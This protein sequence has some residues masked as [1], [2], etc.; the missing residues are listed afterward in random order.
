MKKNLLSVGYVVE[1]V[2]GGALLNGIIIE[3]DT[4]NTKIEIMDEQG[5]K[6]V[7]ECPYKDIKAS[8]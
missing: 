2:K 8:I 7:V 6:S 4:Y 5:V 3:K 1:F